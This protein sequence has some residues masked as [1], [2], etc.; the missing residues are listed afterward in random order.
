[1]WDSVGPLQLLDE[2]VTPTK[3]LRPSVSYESLAAVYVYASDSEDTITRRVNPT[4]SLASSRSH[5]S[6]ADLLNHAEPDSLE[7]ARAAI[8][9]IASFEPN[10]AMTMAPLPKVPSARH[11]KQPLGRRVFHLPSRASTPGEGAGSDTS[12]QRSFDTES[13]FVVAARSITQ[14]PLPPR[15]L[16]RVALSQVCSPIQAF[17]PVQ[18][19]SG[20]E[21]FEEE[22]IIALEKRRIA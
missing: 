6:L 4:P 13:S 14:W 11:T 2:T 20:C 19:L 18:Y 8:D 21:A 3:N 22:T 15:R 12:S 7:A 9:Y 16:S 10:A 1:M 5:V 17:P